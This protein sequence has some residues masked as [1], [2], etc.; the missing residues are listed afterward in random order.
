MFE[1]FCELL[2]IYRFL[3]LFLRFEKIYVPSFP[4]KRPLLIFPFATFTL[5]KVLPASGSY[6]VILSLKTGHKH[7]NYR[8]LLKHQA[9]ERGHCRGRD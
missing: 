8:D 2:Y 4:S 1:Y 9:A 6:A 3:R 7:P 5:I